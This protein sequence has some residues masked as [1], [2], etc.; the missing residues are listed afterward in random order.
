MAIWYTWSSQHKLG[1]RI[2]QN[3]GR[4]WCLQHL[5]P[6]MIGPLVPQNTAYRCFLL[7]FVEIVFSY[8]LSTSHVCFDIENSRSLGCFSRQKTSIPKHHFMLHYPRLTVL[9]GPLRLARHMRFQGKHSYFTKLG[10]VI[11]NLWVSYAMYYSFNTAS[12]W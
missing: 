10:K 1:D 12:W 3:A 7:E 4:T 8:I 9:L 2:K 11:N 6:M 5:L